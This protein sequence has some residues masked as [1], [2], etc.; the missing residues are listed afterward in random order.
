MT[1]LNE[2]IRKKDLETSG[3]LERWDEMN[4]MEFKREECKILHLSQ[5]NRRWNEE[6]LALQWYM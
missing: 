5:K 1:K 4:R 3:Q 6:D 2:F